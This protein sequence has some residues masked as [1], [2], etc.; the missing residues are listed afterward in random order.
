MNQK[1]LGLLLDQCG[2]NLKK[3]KQIHARAIAF[4][5]CNH[6]SHQR[7]A[8]KLLNA[9]LKLGQPLLAHNVFSHIHNPDVV[10]WTSLISL[11]LHHLHHPAQA[12]CLFSKLILSGLR[13]DGFSVVSALSACG[14]TPDLTG[15]KI[16]HA[17]IFRFELEGTEPIV[18]N[19]LIDM[20]SRNRRIRSAQT[21][22]EAMEVKD[23]ASWT[24][25][26]NGYVM[27]SDLESARRVF[28]KM[29]S[30]NAISWTAMIV[31]YVRGESPI[32][33]MQLFRQMMRAEGEED[34]PTCVTIV[35]VLS[36]CADIGAFDLGQSVQGYVNKVNLIMDVSVKNAFIDL[37]A[38]SGRLYFAVKI[39]EEIKEKDVFSWTTIISAFALHGEGSYALEAFANMLEMGLTPNE[40]TF[41]SVLSACSHAGLV[42]EG[43]RLF[44]TLIQCYVLKPKIEH[45]GCMVDLLCRAGHLD[46]AVELIERMPIRPDAVIWRSLLS[47]CL[48][49]RNLKLAEMVGN[50]LLELEPDDDG[51]YILLR[52]MYCSE[53][54]W[55]DALKTRK[56]MR[57]QK[58]KKRP[59]CSWIEVNG[60][61]QE[62]LAD[63]TM[64][65]ISTGIYILLGV[66]NKQSKLDCDLSSL[67]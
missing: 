37:Y 62:F 13:P 29:P 8:C 19:A 43:Q 3:L 30:R 50:K 46:E 66:I 9:Y 47:A 67:E 22:F 57:D 6:H 4:G 61:V 20:Y 10:S 16:V 60:V 51:V 63:D 59:G 36:G 23:V 40:V 7:L 45:Y 33:A 21:V 38:K 31:G 17:M 11:Y 28:D 55:E 1:S 58:I 52:N 32:E 54:R 56:M 5:L 24:S 42:V 34:F 27:C 39:F 49:R 44:N 53:N 12:F 35:A 15:G 41:L 14:R 65:H 2:Q 64:H 48:G 25:L 18:G 26:L